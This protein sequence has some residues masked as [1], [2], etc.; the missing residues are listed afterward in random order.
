[1]SFSNVKYTNLFILDDYFP[2]PTTGFRIAEFTYLLEVGVATKVLTTAGSLETSCAQL[3]GRYPYLSEKVMPYNT[4]FLREAGLVYMNFL[5]NAFFFLPELERL[6]IP[7]VFTL[8]PGG[9]LSFTDE[10]SLMKL[11]KVLNSPQLEFVITTQPI[12]TNYLRDHFAHVRTEEIL[13]V[14]I[15]PLYFVPGAGLRTNYPGNPGDLLKVCFVAH[16][17]TEAGVDKGLDTFLE[18]VDILEQKG[19]NVEVTLVGP[20]SELD[21]KKNSNL[22]PIRFVGNLN[23]ERLREFFLDQHMLISPNKPNVL[24]KGAFDGFPLATS[25]E[26]MLSGV[27]VVATDELAQNRF[28]QDGR[29]CLIDS[30][31]S[32]ILAARILNLLSLNHLLASMAQSGLRVA[33][34][35]YSEENQLEKRAKLMIGLI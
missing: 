25:V 24:S 4:E 16:R 10:D 1:M 3:I 32:E 5:N 2:N 18:I 15:N 6:S 12:V 19:I 11:T 27:L 30:P 22:A 31:N 20:W 29:D 28:L 26:A 9:G 8:Y 23:T 35:H 13:G 7:F 14:P 17:Y 33:R 21:I 34:K